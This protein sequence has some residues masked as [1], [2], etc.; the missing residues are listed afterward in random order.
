[1][2]SDRSNG[3]Q[4][5]GTTASAT[6]AAST[7]PVDASAP[8]SDDRALAAVCYLLWPIALLMLVLPA[9]RSKFVRF[10]VVPAIGV[11]VL[12]VALYAA[13]ALAAHLPVIGWQSALMVPFLVP[14]WF[15]IDLWLAVRAYGGHTTHVPV[16]ADFAQRYAG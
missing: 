9:H 5:N 8:P 2:V 1:M 3:N 12:G 6:A 4:T 15:L 11:N 10:H 14:V 16:A 13:Y 7:S